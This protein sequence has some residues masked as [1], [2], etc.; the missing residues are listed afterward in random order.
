MIFKEKNQCLNIKNLS[1]VT[2]LSLNGID[3]MGY[4]HP[5]TKIKQKE[6]IAKQCLFKAIMEKTKKKEKEKEQFHQHSAL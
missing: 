5:L 1:V 4:V 2:S 6:V 3:V